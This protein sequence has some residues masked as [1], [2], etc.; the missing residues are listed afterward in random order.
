MSKKGFICILFAGVIFFAVFMSLFLPANEGK[1]IEDAIALPEKEK[2]EIF[3]VVKGGVEDNNWWKAS[4]YQQ[5]EDL[6]SRY[7]TG[8]FLKRITSDCWSFI[9]RPTDWY[10]QPFLKEIKISPAE[11]IVLVEADLELKDLNNG[12]VEKGRAVF[13]LK[14]T[15][16]GWRIF[17]ASYHWP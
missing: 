1:E 14:K 17:F 16:R 7:Y 5:L 2:E 12:Q 6:L 3:A 8:Y 4:N 9:S 15:L 10:W 13:L 11:D